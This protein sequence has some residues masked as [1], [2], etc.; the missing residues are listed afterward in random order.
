MQI[1]PKHR[2]CLLYS[3]RNCFEL[4]ESVLRNGSLQFTIIFYLHLHPY[5]SLAKIWLSTRNRIP[6]PLV[7]HR[8]F[9]TVECSLEC[10]F[11]FWAYPMWLGSGL[12]NRNV[13]FHWASEVSEFSNRNFCWMESAPGRPRRDSFSLLYFGNSQFFWFYVAFQT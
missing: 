11:E 13:P 8:P 1:W 4:F 10:N 7:F 2:I 3:S 5:F 12:W 9:S 6:P